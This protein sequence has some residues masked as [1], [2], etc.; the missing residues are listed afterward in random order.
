VVPETAFDIANMIAPRVGFV[1]D[2]TAEGR[3]K[4]MAHWGRFY[5]SVPMDLNVRAFGGEITDFSTTGCTTLN[6]RDD[7][8]QEELEACDTYRAD[9]FQLGDGAEFVAPSLKGQYTDELI[10]GGEYEVM[11]DFKMGVNFV[12]RNMP[13]VIEDSSTDG[14]AHYLIVNPGEDFSAD[15]TD[16]RTEAAGLM[17]RRTRSSPRCTSARADVLDKIKNFD[18]PVRDYQG[19]PDH[20]A[21]ALREERDAAGVVHL[22]AQQG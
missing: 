16:L 10:L 13:R 6:N 5:E 18:K 8:T 14:G 20:R 1:W 17:T 22:L 2:P 19:G 11:A 4:L 12:T 7:V 21:A 3:A 9:N 15:A